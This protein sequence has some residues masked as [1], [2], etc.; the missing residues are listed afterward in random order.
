MTVSEDT[1]AALRAA[2][3]PAI[4]QSLYGLGIVNAFVAGLRPANPKVKPF[5]GPAFTLRAIPAR[6]DLRDDI[7]AGRATNPHRAAMRDVARGEV[8]VSGIGG[9]GSVSMFGDMI[10]TH[11]RSVGCAGIVTD[12]GVADLAALGAVDLP[13]FSAGSAPVPA[14]AR[15]LIVGWREPVDC[16]GVPV[17]P[18]DIVV[19]DGN[20]VVVLPAHLAAVVAE[21]ALA[22]ERL[23]EF[24]LA[25]LQGGAPLD[26]TYP[27]DEATLAAYREAQA[28]GRAR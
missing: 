23:E 1:L 14:S 19:G 27:P 24:L 20:G 10:A 9:L 5:A 3:V 28:D 16:R 13:V 11:L 18:G 26:G 15:V 17:Y 8:I 12:G 7:A 22:K 2:G 25:R 21:K 4:S 6:E